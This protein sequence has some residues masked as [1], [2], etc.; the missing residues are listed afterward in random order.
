MSENNFNQEEIQEVKGTT[1]EVKKGKVG[2]KIMR[3]IGWIFL[4]VGGAGG[5]YF[6][7][8]FMSNILNWIGQNYALKTTN[9]GFLDMLMTGSR[10][11]RSRGTVFASF[12]CAILLPF[13]FACVGF[14]GGALLRHLCKDI[15]FKIDG[16]A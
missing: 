2:G 15:A 14:F 3:V 4:L 8:I 10:E 6:G 16:V 5:I 11:M 9:V 13:V 1:L 12:V 7:F